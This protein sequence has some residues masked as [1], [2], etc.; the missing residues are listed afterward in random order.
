[1]SLPTPWHKACATKSRP[2]RLSLLCQ[3]E[4]N[5]HKQAERQALIYILS[6]YIALSR[7]HFLLGFPI[8]YWAK[9]RLYFVRRL[10]KFT[11]PVLSQK[12]YFYMNL[13]PGFLLLQAATAAYCTSLLLPAL[14][15]RSVLQHKQGLIYHFGVQL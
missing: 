6:I 8:P 10:L 9:K 13:S 15:K 12:T 7:S 14:L 4:S 1:M 3:E 5:L 11:E 2:L